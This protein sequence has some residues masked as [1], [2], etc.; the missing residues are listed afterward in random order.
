MIRPTETPLLPNSLAADG[1]QGDEAKTDR[2][3]KSDATATD[4]KQQWTDMQERPPAA[5]AIAEAIALLS[6]YA[7]TTDAPP[8]SIVEV[9]DLLDAALAALTDRTER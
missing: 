5:E 3:S 6:A 4:K 9:A 7:L 2:L 8:A 1:M